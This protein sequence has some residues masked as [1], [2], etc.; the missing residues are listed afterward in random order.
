MW[1]PRTF[2][3]ISRDTSSE[4]LSEYARRAWITAEEKGWHSLE[5]RTL[6]EE[7]ALMHTELSEVIE[8]IRNGRTATEIYYDGSKP[9]GIP[10]ELADLLIRVLDTCESRGIPLEHALLE[11][12][13]YNQSR[14]F[15][16]GGK[17]L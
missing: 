15:L 8:E 6:V 1:E 12:M 5:K 9:C 16:H 10:V 11:K 7:I 17:R 14:P 13:H 2:D 3:E 4:R